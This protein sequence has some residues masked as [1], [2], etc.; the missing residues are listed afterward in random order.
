MRGRGLSAPPTVLGNGG[1]APLCS[2]QLLLKR[3][4]DRSRSVAALAS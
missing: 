4:G 1:G 3:E 2:K